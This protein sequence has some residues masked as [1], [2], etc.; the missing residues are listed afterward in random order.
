VTFDGDEQNQ[1]QAQSQSTKIETEPSP[2]NQDP[3]EDITGSTVAET[4]QTDQSN[5]A[6]TPERV[7]EI[8]ADLE[9][10]TGIGPVRAESFT[11]AG[12]DTA[13]DLYYA[14]DSSILDV[15]GIGDR[16]LSQIRG[17]IG[18]VDDE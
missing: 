4:S 2:Y 12:F 17:D 8:G 11:V 15:D 3:E 6:A 9:T 7:T 5:E 18:S 14:S 1:Y 16:A 10:I 13:T